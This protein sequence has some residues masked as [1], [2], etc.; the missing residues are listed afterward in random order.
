MRIA[1]YN[2][3]GISSRLPA[4]LQWL[5]EKQPD[6]ACLQELKAPQEKFPEAA[7]K[8]V[9]YEAIW[10]GQ[11]SWNGVAILARGTKPVEVGRGLAGDPED[12]QS[13][14]IEAAVDG[15]LIA[16]LYLPNGNP[17]PGPKFDYKLAW[18]ERLI[19][20]AAD[21]IESG[22]KVVLAGDFNVIPTEL[23]AY[24]PERWV[25]D[26]LFRP[27]TRAAFERLMA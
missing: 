5:E 23:D 11:K 3:N 18:M 16:G 22:Q 8:D 1:T 14:Y 2:V 27:E 10:H 20:R 6:V 24:K 12:A 26:A 7:I 4:L 25:T 19:V 15:V 17:A 9:G 21:L 13:R